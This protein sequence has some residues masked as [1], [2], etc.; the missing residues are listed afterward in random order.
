VI[1]RDIVYH[2]VRSFDNP[3]FLKFLIGNSDIVN[4]YKL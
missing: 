2:N 1:N 3:L 4:A